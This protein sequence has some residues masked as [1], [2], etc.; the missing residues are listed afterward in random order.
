L[1]FQ[2]LK[3]NHLY[4]FI[5]SWF[6]VF[7]ALAIPNF[8]QV[9]NMLNNQ[10][11]GITLATNDLAINNCLHDCSI[12]YNE[13]TIMWGKGDFPPNAPTHPTLNLAAVYQEAQEY[14][15]AY[16]DGIIYIDQDSFMSD[17]YYD[18][19][20]EYIWVDDH[21]HI[22]PHYPISKKILIDFTAF[23]ELAHTI[24]IFANNLPFNS[25]K[26]EVFADTLGVILVAT[27]GNYNQKEVLNLLD[28]ISLFRANHLHINQNSTHDST[29][30]LSLLRL[31]L[32]TQQYPLKPL[33]S[34]DHIQKANQVINHIFNF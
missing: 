1:P 23:H 22:K 32:L 5:I 13:L 15:S 34:P 21:Q 29:K 14:G 28:Y 20:Q 8:N 31:N 2:T 4:L 26:N 25:H 9:I 12:K 18:L 27:S 17:E 24:N 7:Q 3:N 19:V 6:L 30:A 11:Q 33:K 10:S 16:K